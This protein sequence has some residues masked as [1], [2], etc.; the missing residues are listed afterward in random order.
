MDQ[1]FNIFNY[2]KLRGYSEEVIAKNLDELIKI[3]QNI[4]GVLND[5]RDVR[6]SNIDVREFNV[7]NENDLSIGIDVKFVKVGQE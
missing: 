7:V 1:T 6:L 2:L 3:N 5:N 4:N